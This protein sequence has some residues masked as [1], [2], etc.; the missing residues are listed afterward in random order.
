MRIRG[1]GWV[2]VS[3]ILALMWLAR[4]PLHG[5]RL[6]EG[7]A[8]KLVIC[9]LVKVRDALGR[10]AYAKKN[11]LLLVFASIVEVLHFMGTFVGSDSIKTLLYRANLASLRLL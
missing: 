9:I 10:H 5:T 4:V 11:V 6:T 8:S 1:A 3:A 7:V 2:L